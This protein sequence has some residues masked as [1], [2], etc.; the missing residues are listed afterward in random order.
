MADHNVTTKPAHIRA[1]NDDSPRARGDGKIP[2]QADTFH[3]IRHLNQIDSRVG[4][5]C[6]RA[7]WNDGGALDWA[8][9]D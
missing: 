8:L 9:A 6:H 7:R 2:A 1:P 4:G 3:S 5:A